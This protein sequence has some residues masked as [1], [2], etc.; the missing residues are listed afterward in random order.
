MTA[1]SRRL[2][3]TSR[4]SEV[5]AER[6]GE[7]LVGPHADGISAGVNAATWLRNARIAKRWSTRIVTPWPRAFGALK[8]E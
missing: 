2:L 7:Q 5:D 6:R 8:L 1:T 3:T 4:W